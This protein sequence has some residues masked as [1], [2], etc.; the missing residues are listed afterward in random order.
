MHFALTDNS[1]ELSLSTLSLM[2]HQA[3]KKRCPFLKAWLI[4]LNH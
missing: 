1:D 4:P 2:A 3:L